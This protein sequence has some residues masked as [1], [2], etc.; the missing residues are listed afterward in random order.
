MT[1]HKFKQF[2]QSEHL[3]DNITHIDI[4]LSG[5]ADSVCL[6]AFLAKYRDESKPEL[7]LRAHHI[8]H[9]LRDSDELDARIARQVADRFK[10]PFIQTDLHLGEITEN[11]ED[12]A[13]KARYDALFREIQLL[14][15]SKDNICLALAHHGDEN[16]ETALWRLGRGCG[17]EG[18]TLSVKRFIH[19]ILLIR[20]LLCLSKAEIYDYLKE[21]QIP[22]AEDPTNQSDHYLRNRIRHDVLPPLYQTATKPDCIYHSLIYIRHDADSLDSFADFFVKSHP[23][24]FNGWF[25]PY[26]DWLKLNHE[27]QIQVLRHAARHLIQGHELTQSFVY[28]SLEMIQNQHEKHR[29]STDETIST[30]YCKTGVMVWCNQRPELPEPI[31][32][33][34]PSQDLDIYHLY[35]L[36]L[37]NIKSDDILKNTTS[38]IYISKNSIITKSNQLYIYPAGLYK[39]LTTSAGKQTKPLEALRSQ[40]IPDIWRHYWPVLCDDEGPL[41]IL[42]GM[43][44]E[45]AKAGAAYA[46][47]A[48]VRGIGDSQ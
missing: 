35:R 37:F 5:G 47:A 48:H 11:I 40:G 22:W 14:N 36:S 23:I 24:H 19:N 25:C 44:T 43:R 8:R 7:S 2:I 3:A 13:R 42:G 27:A 1:Y 4:A 30:G 41:W 26:H 15:M 10:I 28:Q 39:T 45:R 6:T 20:P 16:A 38:Q 29:I 21:N 32:I 17:L 33:P 12:T 9:G 34:I 18:L 46:I 31:H